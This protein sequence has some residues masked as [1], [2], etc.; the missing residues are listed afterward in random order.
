VRPLVLASVVK[1]ELY[2]RHWKVLMRSLLHRNRGLSCAFVVIHDNLTPAQQAEIRAEYHGVEFWKADPS[3]YRTFRGTKHEELGIKEISPRTHPGFYSL[4]IANPDAMRARRACFLDA[5]MVCDGPIDVLLD[6]AGEVC[7]LREPRMPQWSGA[8]IVV[9]PSERLYEKLLSLDHRRDVNDGWG[10]DQN[11]WNQI[12]PIAT[13][14]NDNTRIV[15]W[16]P[17]GY[18]GGPPMFWHYN[19][20]F[21]QTKA[22]A[23]PN[24]GGWDNTQ[25]RPMELW[26]R[27]DSYAP[28]YPARPIFVFSA[29]YNCGGLAAVN[30]RRLRE[31]G[32]DF[33]QVVVDDGS[34][35][36]T[37]EQVMSA[38]DGD[39]RIKVIRHKRRMYGPY[40]AWEAAH[41][42]DGVEADDVI[43]QVDLDDSLE[44]GALSFLLRCYREN[45]NL[46]MTYGG[47]IDQNGKTHG[48]ESKDRLPT[49]RR[50][51][52]FMTGLRSFRAGL[53][54]ELSEN[55]V[56]F[57][58]DWPPCK[59]DV[60]TYCPMAEMAGRDRILAIR[61][62]FF[63]LQIDTSRQ[64][65]HVFSQST[66]DAIRARILAQPRRAE[67][68]AYRRTP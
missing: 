49:A 12:G 40:S 59:Y 63:R 58:G 65:S 35:D 27:Y 68:A 26:R 14:P 54:W 51:P 64:V 17:R 16:A 50:E 11:L 37:Y 56:R 55:D 39:E 38:R 22:Q 33:R 48:P 5:D 47:V 53:Y 4:E 15:R 30:V 21:G 2:L 57:G 34:T 31:Q 61:N 42:F 19:A 32:E 18:G 6:R 44:P 20:K 1:G 13:I 46:W 3:R 10:T 66:R 52:L 41:A 29:G 7:M 62:R 28:L 60:A 67:L 8:V 24:S 25:D 36:G 45:P 43:L 9:T 23:S